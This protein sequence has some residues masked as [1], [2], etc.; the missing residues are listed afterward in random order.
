MILVNQLKMQT[1]PP[2]SSSFSG[3]ESA[4]KYIFASYETSQKPSC[5]FTLP[6]EVYG[7]N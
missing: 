2:V 3:C 5:K 6:T 7:I 1:P 4:E